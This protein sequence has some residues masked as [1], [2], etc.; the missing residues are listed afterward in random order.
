MANKWAIAART[1]AGATN[2]D[3]SLNQP[4][5]FAYNG[6]AKLSV[7]KDGNVRFNNQYI[8]PSMDGAAD[9]VLQTDGNGN[10]SWTDMSGGSSFWTPITDGINH[11]GLVNIN[12]TAAST[13]NEPALTTIVNRANVEPVISCLLYTSPSPR[14]RTRSRMP[15]SA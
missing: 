6:G 9:Q 10:L 11:N 1:N 8:F 2:Q 5:V 15:S 7:S 12:P 4:I 3:G 13:F 14:D